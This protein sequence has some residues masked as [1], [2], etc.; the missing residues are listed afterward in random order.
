MAPAFRACQEKCLSTWYFFQ[1]LILG[2]VLGSQDENSYSI[3]QFLVL[4]YLP[5]DVAPFG[6]VGL[7]IYH[8]LKQL[9]IFFCLREEFKGHWHWKSCVCTVAN[10]GLVVYKY[11]W[12]LQV[13]WPRV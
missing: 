6:L 12:P 10:Q 3:F 13:H 4:T 11:T 1:L 2:C 5:S 8:C 7:L 9:I